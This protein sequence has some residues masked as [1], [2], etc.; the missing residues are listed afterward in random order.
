MV[1]IVINGLPQSYKHFL[2]TLQITD[3]LSSVTFDSLS[4]LLAQHSK[5]FGKKN[6]QEKIFFSLKLK[7]LK[8]E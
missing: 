1:S 3:N 5:S 4:E 2:E 6:D 8:E 7:V